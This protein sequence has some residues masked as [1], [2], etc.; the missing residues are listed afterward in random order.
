MTFFH[1]VDD[2]ITFQAFSLIVAASSGFDT[3]TKLSQRS[4]YI[5]GSF[6]VARESKNPEASVYKASGMLFDQGMRESNSHQRFWRPLSYH[7]TNPL[8]AAFASSPDTYT[9]KPRNCQPPTSKIRMLQP[10]KSS[11][12]AASPVSRYAC[13]Y[14]L[15][16][17]RYA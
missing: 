7:L 4:I 12:P 9:R 15:Y 6:V 5:T 8:C 2:F 11:H 14:R 3:S 10:Q 13:R 1:L 17:S 16:F